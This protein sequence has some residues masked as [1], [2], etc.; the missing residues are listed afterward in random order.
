MKVLNPLAI[1]DIRLLPGNVLD[2][3]R[4]HQAH[5]DLAP[6]Q[7]LKERNPVD[8][9]GLHRDRSNPELLEQVG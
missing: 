6:F 8:A 2:V 7:D 5:F 9:G 3:M 1:L 4:V